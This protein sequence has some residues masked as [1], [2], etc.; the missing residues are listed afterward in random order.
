MN[1][2]HDHKFKLDLQYFNDGF[3][4]ST[5][6]PEIMA[7]VDRQRTQ[8]SQTAYQNATEKLKKD[9]NFINDIR[10]QLEDE[11]KLS[12]EEKLRI[13]RDK[14][15]SER[16]SIAMEKNTVKALRKL[17]SEGIT[18]EDAEEILGM[19]VTSDE[20]ET[21]ERVD[22]YVTK[23]NRLL[24]ARLTAEKAEL[25]KG[26]TQ[27]SSTSTSNEMTQAKFDEMTYTQQM[28]FAQEHPVLY[29]KFANK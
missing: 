13:E 23:F 14:L 3:D 5:L 2:V 9:D 15:E 4:P 22:K 16:K 21:M 29:A 20:T 26:M 10:K 12:A 27:P 24:D 18:Q 25:L 19:L 7:W 6:S 17:V 11:A 8:A 28:K 1:K